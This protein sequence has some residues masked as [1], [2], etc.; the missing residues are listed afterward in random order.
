M[1]LYLTLADLEPNP[2][3]LGLYRR[4]H[5]GCFGLAIVP[6]GVLSLWGSHLAARHRLPRGRAPRRP[7]PRPPRL[8]LVLHR[9]ALARA[10][11]PPGPERRAHL[12][13]GDP[14]LGG[15]ARV[16]RDGRQA[17]AVPRRFRHEAT[18]WPTTR[19]PREIPGCRATPANLSRWPLA[20]RNVSRSGRKANLEQVRLAEEIVRREIQLINGITN[21]LATVHNAFS[22]N[23]VAHTVRISAMFARGPFRGS[24]N[25]DLGPNEAVAL[26]HRVGSDVRE[27]LNQLKASARESS[28]YPA[29]TASSSRRAHSA[30]R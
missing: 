1:F 24:G 3:R 9:R 28:R 17:I 6:T 25:V 18:N 23:H 26:K 13:A 27:A 16:D 14:P 10:Q 20:P 2:S 7:L 12:D 30:D 5:S 11:G 21:Q 29:W 22:A 19:A 15:V 4:A 8:L